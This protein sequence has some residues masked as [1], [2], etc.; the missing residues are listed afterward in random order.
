MKYILTGYMDIFYVDEN[1]NKVPRNFGNTNKILDNIKKY[2]K[3]YDN[4]LFITSSYDDVKSNDYFATLVF[5]SFDLTLP[6]KNYDILDKRNI[7]DM[8]KLISDA[9]LIF[10]C[11]GH[12]PT[13][14]KYFNDINLKKYITNTKAL[15]IGGSGAAM[16]MAEDVYAIPELEGEALDKNFNKYLK[17]LCI[18][19]ISILPHYNI[20]KDE[21]IDNKK[22][23]E[24]IILP[25]TYN[26]T[27]YGLN[28][29]SYILVINNKAYLY[30]EAYLLK[31]GESKKINDDNKY[32]I[33]NSLLE[34]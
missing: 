7:N 25:D 30:G 10:I 2:V 5:K 11:G 8:D 23:L 26:K 6:F 12:I 34:I 32:K 28:N 4:F 1:E 33:I 22:Y 31:N 21:Y 19:N 3:K 17:G 14:N 29:G 27:L 15:I 16:N 9:D 13:Q 20:F 18:T 24:D